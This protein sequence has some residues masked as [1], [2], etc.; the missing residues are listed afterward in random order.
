MIGIVDYGMGNLRSVRNAVEN[1]GFPSRIVDA[2]DDLSGCRRLILP[3]VGS[4]REAMEN[5]RG[6][7]W[8]PAL[9]RAVF[10]ERTPILGICLGMQLFLSAGDEDGPSEGLGWIEGHVRR[11]EVP[12]GTKLP[13]VGFNSVRHSPRPGLLSGV[14]DLSDF[15]FVHSYHVVPR[16]ASIVTSR[17]VHGVEFASSV[18]TGSIFGTQFHPE[19]SQG[20][21]LR[22]L[23]AFLRESDP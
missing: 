4:F 19:K 7:G 8:V 22:L 11:L 2:P 9:E 1:L 14:E 17:A 6:R 16:D 21:G 5:I 10:G 12:D 13:H 15:Y 18:Q 3:G 20:N 23:H